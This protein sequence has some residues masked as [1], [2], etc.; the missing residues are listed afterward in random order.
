MP[1]YIPPSKGSIPFNFSASGYQPPDF[2]KISAEFTVVE[3]QQQMAALG[4]AIKGIQTYQQET[5]T[6]L[7][8]CET[9]IVGYSQHGVQIIKGRCHYGG[10]RDLGVN[11]GGHYPGNLPAWV[12]GVVYADLGAEIIGELG[13]QDV[14]LGA[15]IGGHLP[16]DLGG[17]IAAHDPENLTA[18]IRG[19]DYRD[20]GAA[21][22]AFRKGDLPAEIVPI[23]PADLPAYL[24]VWPMEVLTGNIYG[25]DI[26]DLGAYVNT[27]GFRD[28]P[29]IIAAHPPKNL[30]GIIKGWVREA[31][32]DLGGSIHGFDRGDLGAF[33]RAT[34]MAQLPASIFPI[35]PAVLQGIIYGWATAD[36]Q[37]I[38]N[39]LDW[40]WNLPASIYGSGGL[41]DLLAQIHGKVNTALPYDLSAYILG[42]RGQG[43]LTASTSI[44]YAGN[45]SASVD[46]GH[47]I[48]NLTAE[49]HPK[50]IR[51]TG[52]LSMVTMEHWDLSA[53]INIPCFYTNL[54]DL[55]VYIRPVHKADLG[56]TIIPKNYVW[57]E[58]NLSATI[59]YAPSTVVQ[60]RLRI[61]IFI[62]PLGFRTEDKI[63][64]FL[65][66]SRL[67]IPLGASITGV[68]D[69]ANLSA[70]I[71]AVDVLPYD[72]EVWKGKA[73]VYDRHYNQIF[74]D[75]EDVDISF[76]SIVRDYFYSSGSDVVAKIDK[77]NHFVTKVASYYSP[78]K[79][80]RLDRR[81]HKVKYLYDMRQFEDVDEAIR[82]AIWY[83][84]TD[85]ER[86]LSAYINSVHPTGSSDMTARIGAKRTFDSDNDLSS[87]V[88]GIAA[89]AYDVV[90][91]YEDD[92]VDYLD[93]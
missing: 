13:T 70:Y 92:G 88:S 72:F 78:S 15:I 11:I 93:F 21:I 62:E 27:I 45:L 10:I 23:P 49:I 52:V 85:P 68:R 71:N 53:T 24:K 43:N 57:G 61:G 6:F 56:A 90:I 73:P 84:T 63:H 14:D 48:R 19:F 35:P 25:W 31:I 89:H 16:V 44:I 41:K 66:L 74:K 34:D 9:Y 87:T 8:Y 60:D 32:Y 69:P 37:G 77:Y 3:T 86:N 42:T 82:F 81:L 46:T 75:Y 12:R 1:E 51:L 28:L 64:L 40:P 22:T 80:R 47:D 7:K 58:K 26:K 18:Y 55:S 79:A 91:G 83:V 20:L 2:D 30:K 65:S 50:R 4:A 33:I 59:G 5:F 76:R 39:G 36:L 38:I 17:I 29:A 67:S 54:K